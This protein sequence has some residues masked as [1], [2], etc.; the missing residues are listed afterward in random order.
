MIAAAACA[1]WLPSMGISN[2][3]HQTYS[4]SELAQALVDEVFLL[5]WTMSCAL[6][7]VPRRIMQGLRLLDEADA[8][9]SALV[10]Q[11]DD[12]WTLLIQWLLSSQEVC[13]G[14]A[15]RAVVCRWRSWGRWGWWGRLRLAG[16]GNW[17]WS[18]SS[19]LGHRFAVAATDGR[20]P[21]QGPL[22]ETR[23]QIQQRASHERVVNS[24]GPNILGRRPLPVHVSLVSQHYIPTLACR[25]PYT[26]VFIF[27][28]S[29]FCV[30]FCLMRVSV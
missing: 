10:E 24:K 26:L 22:P 3:R 16:M 2:A 27:W 11:R 9:N 18:S 12:V 28:R 20:L 19:S 29:S 7:N 5:S 25:L 30:E 23:L 4:A 1:A 17:I 6:K 21:L 14:V 13:S 15:S 8:N